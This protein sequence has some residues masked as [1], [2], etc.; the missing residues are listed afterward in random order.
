MP[1]LN[2]ITNCFRNAATQPKGTCITRQSKEEEDKQ[3]GMRIES[4]H[5]RPVRAFRGGNGTVLSW[6]MDF[7]LHFV[8]TVNNG[9]QHLLELILRLQA[10]TKYHGAVQQ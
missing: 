6:T 10:L 9:A 4:Q 3:M 8:F 7:H 1:Q 2:L 5:R